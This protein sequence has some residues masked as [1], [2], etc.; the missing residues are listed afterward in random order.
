MP[1]LLCF[2]NNQY[3]KCRR[4]PNRAFKVLRIAAS[5][6]FAVKHKIFSTA[7]HADVFLKH[8]HFPPIWLGGFGSG[9]QWV[10]V[11]FSHSGYISKIHPS[12][13]SN[14]AN[15]YACTRVTFSL[16]FPLAKT[17]TY[18]PVLSGNLSLTRIHLLIV[19]IRLPSLY[20]SPL[21]CGF[22]GSSLRSRREK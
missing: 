22:S 7:A 6:S 10:T 17:N 19:P 12:L 21:I 5:A 8:L 13:A 3:C 11:G 14:S 4:I 9:I 2:A 16:G 15:S 1:P 18:S 20:S